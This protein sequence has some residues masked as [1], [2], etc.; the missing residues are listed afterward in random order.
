[1][2]ATGACSAG[3]AGGCPPRQCPGTFPEVHCLRGRGHAPPDPPGAGNSDEFGR[4]QTFG[5]PPFARG[6]AH[7]PGPG[8]AACAPPSRFR[9]ALRRPCASLRSRD[10]ARRSALKTADLRARWPRAPS[11]A[12][13]HGPRRPLDFQP[14]NHWSPGRLIRLSSPKTE[15][16]HWDVVSKSYGG[17][18]EVGGGLVAWITASGA[19]IATRWRG[20]A[21]VGW[22]IQ[23]SA[24][25]GNFSPLSLGRGRPPS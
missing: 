14:C 16:R 4:I 25:Q 11:P 8:A 5:G 6:V 20:F 17:H 7:F 24:P 13:W 1:M 2:P 15:R 12:A 9:R 3:P 21:E 19:C 10:T 22:A 18:L 23:S